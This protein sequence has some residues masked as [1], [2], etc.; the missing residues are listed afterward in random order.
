MLNL[1]LSINTD[2][3]KVLQGSWDWSVGKN[4]VP[5]NKRCIWRSSRSSFIK[6]KRY[7][8]YCEKQCRRHYRCF[9]T[10][11][12]NEKMVDSNDVSVIYKHLDLKN[13]NVLRL[14]FSWKSRN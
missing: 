9:E 7:N 6:D 3:Q 5:I 4:G 2:V 12:M 8:K 13:F 14:S 1:K 10:R 11:L